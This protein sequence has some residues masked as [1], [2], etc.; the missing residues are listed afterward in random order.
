MAE[1]ITYLS[2]GRKAGLLVSGE[3]NCGA[4][5]RDG[6]ARLLVLASDASENARRRAEGFLHGR[7][8]PCVTAPYT[9]DRISNAVGKA[10]CSMLA[11]TDIGLALR[12]AEA[13][14]A[15]QPGTAARAVEVLRQKK[16]RTERR[17][18]EQ[19]APKRNTKT[20]KRRTIE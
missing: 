4:L 12:F 3:D 6:R 20:G 15:A 9:K 17:K 1:A 19:A 14:E 5:L 7:Q 16:A 13:L 2:L 10:G 11:F 8:I 18:T